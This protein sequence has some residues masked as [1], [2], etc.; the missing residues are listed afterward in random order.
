MGFGGLVFIGPSQRDDVLLYDM[1]LALKCF[2]QEY[3]VV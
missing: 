3:F 2:L 1:L